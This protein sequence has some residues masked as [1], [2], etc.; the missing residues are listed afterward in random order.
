MEKKHIVKS[1]D[2]E[3]EELGNKVAEL[4]HE[5]KLQLSKA[6]RALAECDSELAKLVVESDTSLNAL[7]DE[8]N[9]LTVTIL[10][11]RQPVASDLRTVISG[12]KIA[13]ELERI[14]DY[15]CNV[16]RHVIS[17]DGTS[18]I[19]TSENVMRMGALTQAMLSGIIEAFVNLDSDHAVRIWRSDDAV[20]KVF[21]EL[22]QQLHQC[23]I[24]SPDMV[25]NCTA[26]LFIGRCFERIGDHVTNIAESIHYIVTG[27][28]HIKRRP[29]PTPV[30]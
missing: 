1:Y 20:D 23:M 2:Q 17:L 6:V 16:A 28:T 19:E 18:V 11:K 26:L 12:Q 29:D 9:A 27:E 24:Q 30:Q 8:V 21:A 13:A 14:A 4:G 7:Q 3:L 5:A 10:S 15:A 22:L 25:R